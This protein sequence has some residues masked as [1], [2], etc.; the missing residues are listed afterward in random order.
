MDRKK[1]RRLSWL[2][3]KKSNEQYHYFITY[4][5][6]IINIYSSINTSL[7]L[8]KQK[9]TLLTVCVKDGYKLDRKLFNTCNKYFVDF[10]VEA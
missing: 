6:V 3:L 8:V 2:I 10:H 5:R 7:L 9:L 4:I 1:Y